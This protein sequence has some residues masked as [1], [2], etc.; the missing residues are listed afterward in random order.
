MIKEFDKKATPKTD[1]NKFYLDASDLLEYNEI[2]V[3]E[4]WF[5]EDLERKARI[6][7]R[8]LEI[9]FGNFEAY[10]QKYDSPDVKTLL[11]WIEREFEMQGVDK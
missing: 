6:A 7:K 9:V 4:T 5:A 1:K 10:L 3:V 2:P 11:N 8:K